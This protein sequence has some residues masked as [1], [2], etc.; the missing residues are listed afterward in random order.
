MIHD[1]FKK[2]I[3]LINF[4]YIQY[5]QASKY[6]WKHSFVIH[7]LLVISVIHDSEVLNTKVRDSYQ[8]Y[9]YDS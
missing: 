3:R 5:S 4:C 2:F 1:S 8:F 6:Q 7:D 9:S